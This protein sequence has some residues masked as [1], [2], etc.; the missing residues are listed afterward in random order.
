MKFDKILNIIFESKINVRILRML[1]AGSGEY[2]CS[3]NKIAESLNI[4]TSTASILLNKLVEQ[5]I[6]NKSI[7]GN[8][9]KY[10]FIIKKLHENSN[11]H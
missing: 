10:Y 2:E 11:K 4:S 3:G 8:T 7:I 6:L 1:S 5:N 9:H